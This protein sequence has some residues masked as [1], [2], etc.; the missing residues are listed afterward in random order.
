MDA[1]SEAP[2]GWRGAIGEGVD[3]HRLIGVVRR[4]L[5]L[6]GAVFLLALVATMAAIGTQP[7]LYTAA[8]SLTIDT[9]KARVVDAEAVLSGLTAEAAVID[10]EVEI[11]RS[12]QLAERVV[13]AL[14]LI[15][16]PEFAAS[17]S[18]P[19]FGDADRRATLVDPQA[20]RE[21][22]VDAVL[23]RLRIAR[24]GGTYVMQV[25]FESRDPAKAARIANAFADQYLLQQRETKGDAT[26]HA[27][28]WLTGRLTA[29][30][31]ELE[32]AEGAVERYRAENGLLSADG[33]TLT[34]QEISAYSQQRATARSQL[35]E[36][37]A[38]L[39]TARMQLAHGSSGEDV[40]EALQSQVVQ[41]LRAR[42]AE[43][44]ARVA[45]LS[46]RYGERHPDMVRARRELSDAD[47]QI[48]A[49]IRRIVSNLEA[50]VQV[51]QERAGAV[52]ASLA[53]ARLTLA[54][55]NAAGVRLNEL[56]R[57]ADSVRTLYQSFLARFQET[58]AA[59]GAEQSDA[60]IV[61]RARTP[62]EP[63]SPNTP[64]L[65]AGGLVAALMLALAAV[66]LAEMLDRG[67]RH[68][69]DVEQRLGKPSLGQA[70]LL[71]SVA[72][73]AD[74][75]LAPA[76]YVLKRPLSPFAEAF[77]TLRAAILHSSPGRK[78]QVV[79]L[80]SALPGE[81]KSTTA[82]S[83][84][85]ISALAGGKVVLVDCD[86]RRR[87]VARMLRIEPALGLL[88]VLDGSATLEEA[89]R[90][91]EGSGAWVLPLARGGATPRDVLG[92]AEMEALTARLRETFDLV[93]LDTPPL[94][95]TSEARVLAARADAAVLL[96]RW[97]RTP[98]RVAASALRMLE[99]SGAAA[100]GVVLT[101]VDMNAQA[102]HGY[103]DIDYDYADY[104][105]FAQPRAD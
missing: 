38:R 17:A 104:V 93:I 70:P 47:E 95:A 20:R 63:S 82:L 50:R 2:A 35:A 96:A 75:G 65:L 73:K 74:R 102:R 91:D 31:V 36:E 103:G 88:E 54:V 66:G 83:L 15:H 71:R 18:S 61:S 68:A 52:D 53:E 80:C 76:D 27:N 51:A 33:A 29:L 3:P 8:A 45:D 4:R 69:E 14:G 19:W 12:R 41:Q 28:S 60:R 1:R 24:T 23:E 37:A 67:L 99:H 81:G 55:D 78:V 56:E 100:V 64:L 13:D 92:G 85:R 72:E 87:A 26:R 62:S 77:R 42:R 44:S 86:L 84:T 59:E 30:R 46:S 105:A 39:R 32:A 79:A 97:R 25:A 16:D 101:Q 22:V 11:L 48:E 57:H 10:T 40:G 98:D 7:T 58:S 90:L 5:W 94:L 9:R 49:E 34:E 43:A 89:L 6:A 21:L